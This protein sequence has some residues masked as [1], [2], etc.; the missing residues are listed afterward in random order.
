MLPS[1]ELYLEEYDYNNIPLN[2]KINYDIFK[3]IIYIFQRTQ[4]AIE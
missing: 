1:Y 3:N 2:I 4:V